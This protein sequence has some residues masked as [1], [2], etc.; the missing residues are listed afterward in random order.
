MAGRTGS[1]IWNFSLGFN[2]AKT[3]GLRVAPTVLASISTTPAL[4]QAS[5]QEN[6]GI[7]PLAGLGITNH[8]IHRR[9]P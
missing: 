5:A 4:A 6:C 2:V 8:H 3:I 7:V 9:M 1:H